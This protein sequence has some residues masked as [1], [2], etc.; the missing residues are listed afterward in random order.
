M[1][2][3]GVYDTFNDKWDGQTAW[4]IADTHFGDKELRAGFPDRPTDEE[5]VKMINS[6]AG[7]TDVLILLGDVGDIKYIQQLRAGY[8]ILICGNHDLGAS[9]YKRKTEL[10][11]YD[12]NLTLEEVSKKII[13]DYPKYDRKI[14]NNGFLCDINYPGHY[15]WECYIDN[16]LF[17]EVYT[18]PLM[19]GEKLILSH[20]PVDVSW[21]YNIHGHI[22]DLKHKNDNYHLNVCADV[23]GYRP[24]NLNSFL[25]KSG[26]LSKVETLHRQTIDKATSRKHG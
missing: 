7:R 4:I 15:F 1:K 2:L 10:K 17:D 26:A 12:S 18:G 23:L 19:I 3:T 20:E 25:S 8:K 14:I 11:M 16:H 6:C 9:R 5:L 21:A 24:I 13:E 22:H